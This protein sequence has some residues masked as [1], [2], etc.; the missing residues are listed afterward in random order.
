MEAL[1]EVAPGANA[2]SIKPALWPKRESVDDGIRGD[3]SEFKSERFRELLLTR[4]PTLFL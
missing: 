4:H 3:L 2:F 1:T